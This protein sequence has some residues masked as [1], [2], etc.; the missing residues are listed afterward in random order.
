M[1]DKTQVATVMLAARFNAWAAVVSG[2]TLGMMLAN[3][4]VVWFGDRLTKLVPIRIVHVVSAVIFL[5]LGAAAL[6]G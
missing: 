2:T 1:G 4:P 6:L 3:A 5:G